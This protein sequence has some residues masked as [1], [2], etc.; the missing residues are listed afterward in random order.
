[1]GPALVTVFRPLVGVHGLVWLF[2]LLYLAAA[3]MTHVLKS[4]DDPQYRTATPTPVPGA[5]T[6]EKE[7]AA[8]T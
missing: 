1:M 8:T 3:A 5:R 4:P 2:T 7:N 6:G